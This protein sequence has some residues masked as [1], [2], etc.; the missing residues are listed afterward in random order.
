MRLRFLLFCGIVLGLPA[1]LM[2]AGQPGL[3]DPGKLALILGPAL[4]GNLLCVGVN[5]RSG[6]RLG[7]ASAHA[8]LVTLSIAALALGV[9][10]LLGAADVRASRIP[11][12]QAAAAVAG[13]ALTSVLE[14]LGWARG[15]LV[16]A[17]AAVGRR[18]GVFVLGVVW[19]AWHLIPTLLR[20]GLFPELE[21]APAAMLV[22]FLITS[23]LYRELL[24]RLAERSGSWLAAA[25]GHA[26]PNVLFAVLV[27]GGLRVLISP[28][29]WP[30]FP[31]PGGIGFAVLVVGA[32]FYVRAGA[33]A[34]RDV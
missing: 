31:A 12:E 15:G 19:A 5:F 16:L 23:V 21:A 1:A 26:A 30:A 22:V 6:H 11:A 10:L 13:A 25:A 2:S 29:E 14:E 8:A 24:T 9:A 28:G 4:A 34:G 32:L 33:G 18:T 27:G 3:T 17:T 20:V 7:A